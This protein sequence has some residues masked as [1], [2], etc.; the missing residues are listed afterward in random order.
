MQT[1]MAQLVSASP[2]VPHFVHDCDKCQY[3][4]RLNGEDLYYCPQ[5]ET[6]VRRF[7]DRDSDN[8]AMPVDVILTTPAFTGTP[9]SFAN[10]LHTRRLVGGIPALEW[11]ARDVD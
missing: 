9:Y 2:I 6:F 10:V 5:D 4:G 8:G 7:G 3:L 11:T 1:K